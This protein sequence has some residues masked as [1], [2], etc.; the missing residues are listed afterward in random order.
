M[1]L[2]CEEQEI[3]PTPTPNSIYPLYFQVTV[4]IVVILITLIIISTTVSFN[5][6]IFS[7]IFCNNICVPIYFN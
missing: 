7:I 5:H 3:M 6:P 1:R 4:I 2:V